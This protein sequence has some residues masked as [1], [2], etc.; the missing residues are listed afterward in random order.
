V[1][2]FNEQATFLETIRSSKAA[3]QKRAQWESRGDR[4]LKRYGGMR[5]GQ[6]VTVDP[7]LQEQVLRWMS[8]AAPA[9]A[10][11]YNLY[12]VPIAE[13]AWEAWPMKTGLSKSL[14][15][16]EF[17][18]EHGGAGFRGSIRNRA[19]YAAFIGP[20]GDQKGE[21]VRRLVWDPAEQAAKQMAEHAAADLARSL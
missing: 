10:E 18:I 20:T 11:A 13:R 3:V 17:A 12:L 15:S 14:L 16:L 8:H 1:S 19:P 9:L 2:F 5:Q 7:R 6:L 21:T 4:Y